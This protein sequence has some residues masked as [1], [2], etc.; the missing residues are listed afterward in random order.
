VAAVTK[1]TKETRAAH[2]R[3]LWAGGLSSL[4]ADGETGLLFTLS[5][6][7]YSCEQYSCE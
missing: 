3:K 1:K 7:E 5:C 6:E 2:T 4:V